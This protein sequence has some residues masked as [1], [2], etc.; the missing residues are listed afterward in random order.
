VSLQSDNSHAVKSF[1]DKAK[2]LLDVMDKYT[3]APST[4]K[5]YSGWLSSFQASQHDQLLEI[6]GTAVEY[7][8]PV[9]HLVCAAD[10]HFAVF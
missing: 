6:P 4:L 2:K 10:S 3:Q 9:L 7:L 5:E 8:S 1:S